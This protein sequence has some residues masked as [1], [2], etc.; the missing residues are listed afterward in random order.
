MSG[1]GP[2]PV[3]EGRPGPARAPRASCPGSRIAIS[4]AT[5]DA[6]PDFSKLKPAAAGVLPRVELAPRKAKERYGLEFT[7]FLDVP[8]TGVYTFFLESDDG[9]RLFLGD[10]PR[11]RQRRAARHDREEGLAALAAGPHPI[12]VAY[13]QRAPGERAAASPGRRPGWPSRP[14]PAVRLGLANSGG[15]ARWTSSS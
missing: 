15:E 7:G 5:W 2:G 11:R 1:A 3:R 9:S 10:D 6:L 4:K 12:R 14:I 13:V 8:R